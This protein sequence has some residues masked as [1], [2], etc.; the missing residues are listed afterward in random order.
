MYSF[1]YIL[2]YLFIHLHRKIDIIMTFAFLPNYFKKIGIICFLTAIAVTIIATAV[3]GT[4]VL[5]AYS[6]EDDISFI[7]AYEMAQ[8]FSQKN[9]WVTQLSSI[10]LMLSMAIYM[11]AKEKIDDEYMDIMRWESLRLSIIISIVITVVC[12]LFSW[13]LLAKTA[14]FIQFTTYLVTFKVKKS[15]VGE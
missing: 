6:H 14:L 7:S 9:T 4:G 15:S 2:Q 8:E 12:I 11:L 1:L 13:K 5:S 10:L 3:T